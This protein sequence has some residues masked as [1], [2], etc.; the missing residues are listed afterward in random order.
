MNSFSSF[1]S[2]SAVI[3]L[4][5]SGCSTPYQGSGLRGGYDES[6]LSKDTWRVTF[7]GNA[8]T[9]EQRAVDFTLLRCAELAKSE[10]FPFFILQD[11]ASSVD[12]RTWGTDGNMHSANFPR[13]SN[14]MQGFKTR[15]MDVNKVVYE[16]DY[17]I[18]SLKEKYDLE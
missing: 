2:L 7:T 11:E 17:L 15:P 10:G 13:V 1:L 6:Q 5:F 9:S 8:A 4:L 18:P 16:V 12:S 3:V 14:L